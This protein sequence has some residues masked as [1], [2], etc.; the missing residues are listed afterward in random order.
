MIIIV[1]LSN[2]LTVTSYLLILSEIPVVDFSGIYHAP[3]CVIFAETGVIA[4]QAFPVNAAALKMAGQ[5]PGP[6][7]NIQAGII[8]QVI[9]VFNY[10]KLFQFR[11]MR[12]INLHNPVIRTD[13]FPGFVFIVI[14]RSG[15]QTAFLLC[16]G[17]QKL[18]G[19]KVAF[20]G[21]NKAAIQ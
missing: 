11:N 20:P 4:A 18:R 1:M 2:A 5:Y 12:R 9:F 15:D 17:F 6:G 14:Y 3:G 7:L 8:K 21:L 13:N 10:S 19:N 16:N